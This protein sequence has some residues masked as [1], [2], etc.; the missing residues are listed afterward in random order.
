M[1][2]LLSKGEMVYFGQ[3]SNMV[4]YFGKLGYPCPE[5]TNPCDFYGKISSNLLVICNGFFYV[6]KKQET[7][8]YT[9]H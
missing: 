4:D 7:E 6:L 3:A 2:L 8:H 1:I 5:F 9:P